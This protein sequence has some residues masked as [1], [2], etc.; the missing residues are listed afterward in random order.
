M[1][2]SSLIAALLLLWCSHH[3]PPAHTH[4]RTRPTISTAHDS[5]RA[6]ARQT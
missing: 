6:R 3:R 1:P 4:N 2:S 5:K